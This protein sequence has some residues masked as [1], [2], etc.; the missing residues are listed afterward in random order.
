MGPDPMHY[1][2]LE[3]DSSMSLEPPIPALQGFATPT[4]DLAF[5]YNRT[6]LYRSD[7]EGR[8]SP[9]PLPGPFEPHLL[10]EAPR[11]ELL[12][13]DSM[14][15]CLVIGHDASVRRRLSLG[16]GIADAAT[17]EFGILI[18]RQ[19]G[20]LDKFSFEGEPIVDDDQV[21]RVNAVCTS[22]EGTI[23]LVPYDGS[24]WVNLEDHFDDAGEPRLRLDPVRLF[25]E[26]R[27]SADLLAQEDLVVLTEKGRI[28]AID[29]QGHAQSARYDAKAVQ[30]V[31]G[32]PLSAAT[33]CIATRIDFHSVEDVS[34]LRSIRGM[35]L[36]ILATDRNRILRF[37][38][39]TE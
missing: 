10:I 32:R 11:G 35:W 18:L 2:W 4:P 26:G 30:A 6:G 38:I 17:D 23:L 13:I 12:L 1:L 34:V 37:Q 9:V 21:R 28:L 8:T 33:D 39:Y 7:A 27:V 24:I 29:D 15:D 31:L 25:G 19:S 36:S 14:G 22:R 16:S 5:L 20:T 3:L